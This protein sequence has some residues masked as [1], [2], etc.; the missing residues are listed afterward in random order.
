MSH[1]DDCVVIIFS[2]GKLLITSVMSVAAS[3]AVAI[4]PHSKSHHKG[5]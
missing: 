1:D 2:C 4:G 5:L 3:W